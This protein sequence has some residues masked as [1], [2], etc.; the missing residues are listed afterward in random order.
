MTELGDG[1]STSKNRSGCF[2]PL[3][4]VTWLSVKGLL[5]VLAIFGGAVWPLWSA[6]HPLKP[7]IISRETTLITEPLA[8]DGLPD[9]ARFVL[10][11]Q[12]EG[13]T[14]ENNGAVPFWKAMGP[15][16][17]DQ[18]YREIL[19]DEIGSPIP[20]E[21]GS[22]I[23]LSDDT[24]L[25]RVGEWLANEWGD[26]K[27][28]ELALMDWAD[29]LIADARQ[30]PWGKVSPAPLTAWVEEN[31]VALDLLVEASHKPKF[32]SPS[33]NL[34]TDPPA[35]LLEALLPA[36][37]EIRT[38]CKS[39]LLR[40]MHRIERRDF[41]G[42]WR[43]LEAVLLLSD[44]AVR[45]DD[46]ISQLVGFA[47]RRSVYET[48]YVWLQ[49]ANDPAQVQSILT[50]LQQRPEPFNMPAVYEYGESLQFMDSLLSMLPTARNSSE[51]EL[52]MFNSKIDVNTMFRFSRGW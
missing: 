36:V 13:V 24:T 49:K 41:A 47:G 29:D 40:A 20:S 38:A 5:I 26:E 23:K 45:R 46:I 31:Q 16:N 18:E 37:Q 22:L 21:E 4:A 25:L 11:R 8:A 32:Y 34:L 14:P 33:P 3:F 15:S 43:D 39:L 51:T 19:F 30:Y 7:L 52:G 6:F 12:R 27:I 28:D 50:Y 17:I 10:D 9:Y 48:L 42:A 35:S 2:W 1:E 44:H